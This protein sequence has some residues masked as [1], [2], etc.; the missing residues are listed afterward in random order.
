MLNVSIRYDPYSETAEED[1][2]ALKKAVEQIDILSI[3]SRELGKSSI[4]QTVTKQAINALRV[5]DTSFQ[6]KALQVL[7]EA[8]NLS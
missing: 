2:E 4:D 7:L 3:L 6:E 8:N 1:Y 5:L